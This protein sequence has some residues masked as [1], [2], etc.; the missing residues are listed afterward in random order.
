M[1][2]FPIKKSTNRIISPLHEI[3][4]LRREMDHLFDLS[5]PGFPNGGSS[6]LEGQWVPS[7]DVIDA[8]NELFVKVE[9]PGLTKNDINVQVGNKS[10][11]ITGEKRQDKHGKQDDIL[12]TERHYGQFHRSLQLPTHVDANKAKAK[13][14]DGVLELRLPKKEEFKPKQIAVDIE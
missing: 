13:F 3:D 5:F 1:V 14:K 4:N 11:T 10:L 9:L 7:L 12:R 6:L 2:N 8:K